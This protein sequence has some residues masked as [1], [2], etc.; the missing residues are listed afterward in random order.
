MREIVLISVS[1]LILSLAFLSGGMSIKLKAD[2]QLKANEPEAV[3]ILEKLTQKYVSIS[4]YR[5]KGVAE[6]PEISLEKNPKMLSTRFEI[7]YRNPGNLTLNWRDLDKDVLNSLVIKGRDIFLFEDGKVVKRFGDIATAMLN[8]STDQATS[9]FDVANLLI[10]NELRPGRTMLSKLK[11]LERLE[12]EDPEGNS[13]YR[14]RGE[15][16]GIATDGKAVF[17]FWIEKDSFLLKRADRR[18]VSGGREEFSSNR[19]ERYE[20]I[21]VR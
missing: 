18:L 13:C 1:A 9:R 11:N 10:F 5:S 20:E 19:I 2:T 14:I 6:Y 3:E 7:N 8:V 4:S 12:D 16:P 21:E 15:I 17:T